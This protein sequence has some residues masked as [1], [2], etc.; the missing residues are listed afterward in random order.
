VGKENGNYNDAQI[1][2]LALETGKKKILIEGGTCPRYSPSGHL[3]YG[4]AGSL[5]AVPFDLQKLAVQGQP[6]PVLDGVFMNA[7]TGMAAY[8]I[9][10]GGDLAG[11][12]LVI[13]VDRRGNAMP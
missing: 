1:A 7:G 11:E 9:S 13:W 6:F 4:R 3:V 10:A 2:V 12:R 8:A 5:L